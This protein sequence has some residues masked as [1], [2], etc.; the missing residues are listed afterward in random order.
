[1]WEK[2]LLDGQLEEI[3]IYFD[4]KGQKIEE[5]VYHKNSLFDT[6]SILKTD[7]FYLE[8]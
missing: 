3:Y 5:L 1:M 8:K 4:N 2:Q 7:I 6:I